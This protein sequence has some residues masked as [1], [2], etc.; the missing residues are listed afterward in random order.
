M[1][2]KNLQKI[3]GTGSNLAINIAFHEVKNS[4]RYPVG[5]GPGVTAS[6]EHLICK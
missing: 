5:F 6:C 2:S 1:K 4:P 3:Y